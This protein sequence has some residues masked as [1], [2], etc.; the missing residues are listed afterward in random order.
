MSPEALAGSADVDTRTD[1]YSLGVVLYELLAGVRPHQLKG[2]EMVSRLDVGAIRSDAETPS[3]RV[4]GLDAAKAR[5]VADARRLGA[6]ELAARV[7]G[8]LDWIVMKAIADE[9]ERRY[10]SVAS[11]LPISNDTLRTSRSRRV[12]PTQRTGWAN[13]SDATVSWWSRPG[14]SA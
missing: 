2:G 5:E 13:S 6:S 12:R 9:P 3:T 1:V 11:W 10:A 8:D 7:R 14:W 4:S